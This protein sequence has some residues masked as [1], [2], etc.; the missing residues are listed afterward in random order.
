[1]LKDGLVCIWDDARLNPS[2]S[3]LDDAIP[4]GRCHTERTMPYRKDDAI[5]KGRCHTERTMPYRKDDA[6]IF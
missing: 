5:P 6:I 1:M 3:V 4:K 2:T